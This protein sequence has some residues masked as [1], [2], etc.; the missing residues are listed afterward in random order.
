MRKVTAVLIMS[1]VFASAAAV[2]V[3]DQRRWKGKVDLAL[4]HAVTQ[5]SSDH[6][7]TL[8]LLRPGALAGF[9]SHLRRHGLSPTRVAPPDLIVVDLPLSMVRTVAGD[10][11]VVRLSSD[12]AT[13]GVGSDPESS[14]LHVSGPGTN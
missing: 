13:Q 7:R 4:A 6:V 11:D 10:S 5:G 8:V 2:S 3:R 9:V 12:A 1:C 14:A